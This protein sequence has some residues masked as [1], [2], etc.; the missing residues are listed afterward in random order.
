MVI[1]HPVGLFC[2][3]LCEEH[4]GRGGHDLLCQVLQVRAVLGTPHPSDRSGLGQAQLAEQGIV[5]RAVDQD[6][7]PG[8][9]QVADDKVERMVRP[10]REENLRSAHMDRALSEQERDPLAKGAR[11]RKDSRSSPGRRG[12]RVGSSGF[13]CR[14]ISEPSIQAA[15][16]RP[17]PT[18]TA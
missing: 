7:V 10:M 16:G 18:R 6:R 5:A 2:E 15:G 17:S 4:L 12:N 14:P 3:R 11:S 13:K 1:E 8:L 9:D